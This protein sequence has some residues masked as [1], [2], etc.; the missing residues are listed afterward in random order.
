VSES[1]RSVAAGTL[2]GLLSFG[3]CFLPGGVGSPWAPGLIFGVLVLAPSF[4]GGARRA[5]LLVA[6]VL[7]YRAAVWFASTLYMELSGWPVPACTLAGG[8]GAW[9][10]AIATSGIVRAPL[11][12]RATRRSVTAGA[13]AGAFLDLYLRFAD[14]QRVFDY[15][16]AAACFVVWQASYALFHRLGP[17]RALSPARAGMA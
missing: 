7:T 5:W 6:S 14:D 10:L 13:A 3:A 4:S 1:Q 2:S 8:L 17:W 16:A 12:R 11:E 15:L 9:A